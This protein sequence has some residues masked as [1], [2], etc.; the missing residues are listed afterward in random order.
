VVEKVGRMV[1]D[2]GGG[3][4]KDGNVVWAAEITLDKVAT[5]GD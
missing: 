1:E 4:A 2:I 5:G 3:A